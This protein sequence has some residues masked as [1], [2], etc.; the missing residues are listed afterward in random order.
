MNS[1]WQSE[2]HIHR[3]V[4]FAPPSSWRWHHRPTCEPPARLHGVTVRNTEVVHSAKRNVILIVMSFIF[5]WEEKDLLSMVKPSIQ[6]T[7]RQTDRLTNWGRQSQTDWLTPWSWAL[8]E[9]PP[10]AQLLRVRESE[11]RYDGRSAG[12]SVLLSYSRNP[13][14]FIGPKSPALV[15]ILSQI[16]PVP[17]LFMVKPSYVSSGV[18]MVWELSIPNKTVTSRISV[19]QRRRH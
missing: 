1:I 4:P 10:V 8:P 18:C 6:L 2:S 11:S 17:I 16:S 15:P 14:H 9:K 12:Q 7:D 5:W 19:E 3:H 13:Q